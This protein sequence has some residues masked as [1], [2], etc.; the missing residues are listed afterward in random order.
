MSVL[1]QEVYVIGLLGHPMSLF[2]Y[3]CMTL[4]PTLSTACQCLT[5]THTQSHKDLHKEMYAQ[6]L[7]TQ[8]Q[9]RVIAAIEDIRVVSSCPC[10]L[11]ISIRTSQ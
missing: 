11:L 9:T 4:P 3:C 7:N 1:P 6:T 2:R 10:V 8:T 5:D